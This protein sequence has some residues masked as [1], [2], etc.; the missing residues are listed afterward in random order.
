MALGTLAIAVSDK[1]LRVG[2]HAAQT[3]SEVRFTVAVVFRALTRFSKKQTAIHLTCC[4]VKECCIEMR[5]DK[6]CRWYNLYVLSWS[7]VHASPLQLVSQVH[8]A[9]VKIQRK[10]YACTHLHRNELKAV[11]VCAQVMQ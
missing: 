2:Q 10:H 9:L 7:H 3:A 8:L 4:Q 6:R 1:P 11:Q 5:Q